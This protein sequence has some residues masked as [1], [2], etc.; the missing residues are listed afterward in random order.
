MDFISPHEFRRC[1]N[2]YGGNYKVSTFTCWD[3]FLCLAFAQ[4][5]GRESL[6]EI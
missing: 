4:L 1:V 2:R 3:Q 5:T 6:R